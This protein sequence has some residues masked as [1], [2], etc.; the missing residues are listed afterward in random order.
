MKAWPVSSRV[1]SPK[2]NEAEVI[3]PIEFES[4]SRSEISATIL[5]PPTDRDQRAILLV[6][7]AV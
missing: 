4:V 6:V 7:L 2:N 3:A 1:N 5:M